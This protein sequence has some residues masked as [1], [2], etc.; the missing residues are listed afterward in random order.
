MQAH[1]VSALASRPLMLGKRSSGQVHENY[2]AFLWA[3]CCLLANENSKEMATY[4]PM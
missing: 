2:Q 3:C 4:S 1:K